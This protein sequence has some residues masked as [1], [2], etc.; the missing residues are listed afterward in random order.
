MGDY[1]YQL[2]SGCIDLFR[3]GGRCDA[4]H[5]DHICCQDYGG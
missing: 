2:V 5:A 4:A 3:S 1:Y